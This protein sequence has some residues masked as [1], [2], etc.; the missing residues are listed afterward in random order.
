MQ[1]FG[2]EPCNRKPPE[3]V[4]RGVICSDLCIRKIFPAVLWK[5]ACREQEWKRSRMRATVVVQ[6][7]DGGQCS[8][9]LELKIELMGF[10][11]RG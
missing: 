3:V 10:G 9:L 2:V 7:R 5:T 6:V 11:N 1:V 4:A 8:W